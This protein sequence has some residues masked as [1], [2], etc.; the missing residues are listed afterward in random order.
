MFVINVLKSIIILLLFNIKL[1]K[2]DKSSLSDFDGLLLNLGQ[3]YNLTTK[4]VISHDNLRKILAGVGSGNKDAT[5]YFALLKMYGIT[6]TRNMTI[7]AEH[8]QKAAAL[9]HIEAH[10]AYGVVLLSDRSNPDSEIIATRYFRKAIEMND[11]NA[12]WLLAK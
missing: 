11:L 10:T 6:V 12:P 5:Y 2:S 9:G 3:G 8:F 7:A 1:Y 4:S